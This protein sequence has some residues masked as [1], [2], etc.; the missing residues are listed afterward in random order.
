MRSITSQISKNLSFLKK[1]SL[2]CGFLYTEFVCTDT[3]QSNLYLVYSKV[4]YL[5]DWTHSMSTP[6]TVT[7][8]KDL[9]D[10]QSQQSFFWSM[11]Y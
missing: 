7:G 11:M 6:S 1:R 9:L 8:R 3:D 10:R 4:G 5:H 2:L